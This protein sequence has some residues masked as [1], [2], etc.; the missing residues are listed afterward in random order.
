MYAKTLITFNQQRSDMQLLCIYY[1]ADLF[2]N[3]MLLPND[4]F[5][6]TT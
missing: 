5:E 4:N 6:L 1:F 3:K 2:A